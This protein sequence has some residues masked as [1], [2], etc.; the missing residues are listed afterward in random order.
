MM[1]TPL[2]E[3]L[4]NYTLAE[5]DSII[6][7]EAH[8]TTGATFESDIESTF[9]R[10]HDAKFIR[11][12]KRLYMTA[13]PRIY[14]D[15]A[16]ATAIQQ[17][18]ALC[19]IDD[20]ELNGKQ[21]HVI[22]FSEAVERGLL[23]DYKV[24]VL[25]ID[26]DHVSSRLQD[27]LK[28]DNNQLKVD[29]AARIHAGRSRGLHHPLRQRYFA[30]GVWANAWEQGGPHL[31]PICWHGDI[32]YAADAKRAHY[33]GAVLVKNP[34]AKSDSQ[35]AQIYLYEVADCLTREAKLEL[36]SKYVSK[37]SGGL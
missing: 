32:H 16:K 13:T 5:F 7:D 29:D 30:R 10:V 23:S 33:A 26:E 18:V 14:A 17:N 25:T 9:V 24:I 21:L 36:V 35:S 6:C 11:G 27:L 15:I 1:L 8:R 12:S 37:A 22:T 3:I 31:G 34:L 19:S 20:D 2:Q 28:D 4:S